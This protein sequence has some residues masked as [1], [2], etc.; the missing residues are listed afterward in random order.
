LG[1]VD[2]KGASVQVGTV[3]YLYSFVGVPSFAEAY[4]TETAAAAS[5]AIRDYLGFRNFTMNFK[6]ISQAL[7]I[8]VPTQSTYK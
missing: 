2:P 5:L 3:H 7:V 4:K 1:L 8:G 6:G